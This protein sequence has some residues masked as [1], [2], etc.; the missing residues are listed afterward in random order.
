[1][2]YGNENVVG[3]SQCFPDK[4]I[5]FKQLSISEIL[6]IPD[7][8]PDIEHIISAVIQPNIVSTRIVNTSI[9]Y[10]Y[11]GQNIT[12][13]KLIIELELIEKIKYVA[14]EPVQSIHAAHYEKKYKSIFIV[15]PSKIH[16]IKVETL[17]ENKKIVVTPYI[18]DI[19]TK[20]IDERTIYK[21]ITMLIDVVIIC[22]CS[23]DHNK[24]YIARKE[25]RLCIQ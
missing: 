10:S 21:G 17:L 11:E 1:M 3:V 7:Q 2:L 8:K 20:K 24:K 9:G 22:R 15:I 23:M 4:P 13:K 12:G 16:N 25:D 18:E 5:C 6:T 14:N 19:Y